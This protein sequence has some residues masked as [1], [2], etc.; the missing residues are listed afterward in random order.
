LRKIVSGAAHKPLVLAKIE[1][2]LAV[3]NFDE[4]LRE[5]DGIMVA[6][7]DLGIECPYEE[8][9]LIQRRIVKECIRVGRPVIVATH[10]LE[11]MIESPLPTRAEITDVANAVFEQ[12]DAIMLSGETT[13][14]KY[15]LQCIEVFD[16]ISRRIER[17]GIATYH[18]R[19]EFTSVRQKLVKS[20][21][22]LAD[23]LKAD[24]ILVFTIR[25][26]MAR[27]AASCRP[28]YSPTYAICEFQGIADSLALDWGVEAFVHP[29]DHERPER[30]VESALR[31]LVEQGRL[32]RGHQV[33]VITAISAGEEIADVVEMRTVP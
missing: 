3:K 12:A 6:R 1:D 25:G 21:V 27:H 20:A 24:A 28:R 14:G 4:I 32:R 30:T 5:A 33:V 29:F 26:N 22:V 10:M 15:P 13:V 16:R 17:S 9:P 8:L 19:V 18:E 23:Q 31:W 11:S 7:G 2:Q